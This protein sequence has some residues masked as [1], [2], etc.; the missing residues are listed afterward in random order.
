MNG[1]WKAYDFFV[2]KTF[3]PSSTWTG[4]LLLN[5]TIDDGSYSWERQSV[6]LHGKFCQSRVRLSSRSSRSC[7]LY[8][9]MTDVCAWDA[10]ANSHK[11]VHVHLPSHLYTQIK[12]WTAPTSY[13][14]PDLSFDIRQ[15]SAWRLAATALPAFLLFLFFL[16]L[17]LVFFLL[18]ICFAILY[19]RHRHLG[20]LC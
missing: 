1:H 4:F 11:H 16:F 8:E 7:S 14:S 19:L 17:L 12:T 6:H 3:L 20:I 5:K 9:Q 10:Y 2:N 13:H 15:V 18:F